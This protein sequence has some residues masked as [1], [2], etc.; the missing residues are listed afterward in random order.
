MSRYPAPQA[1]GGSRQVSPVLPPH[2]QDATAPGL[3]AVTEED[4]GS[5]APRLRSLH[6]EHVFGDVHPPLRYA[7]GLDAG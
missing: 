6:L 2:P 4:S 3:R 1:L 5:G 7:R